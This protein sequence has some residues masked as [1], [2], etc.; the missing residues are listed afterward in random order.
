MI[1]LSVTMVGLFSTQR[2]DYENLY[3]AINIDYFQ[4]YQLAT[5]NFFI[6]RYLGF[7]SSEKL[8]PKMEKNITKKA[9]V[10]ALLKKSFKFTNQ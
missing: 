5:G 4:N 7:M 10:I 9:D 1:P 8:S 6:M 3:R 2:K